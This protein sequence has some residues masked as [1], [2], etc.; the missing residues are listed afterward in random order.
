MKDIS[1]FRQA[2]SISSGTMSYRINC[3]RYDVIDAVQF[4]FAD[5][6]L[7]NPHY[8]N[9]MEAW[10]EFEKTVNIPAIIEGVEK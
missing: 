7:E 9:W 5:F 4:A 10:R 3:T 2:L 1:L 8:K 6:C